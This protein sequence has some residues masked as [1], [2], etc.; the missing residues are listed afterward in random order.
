MIAVAFGVAT[1]FVGRSKGG[2]WLLWFAIG[3][4]LP[5]FGL[6]AAFLTRDEQRE[7]ERPCPSCGSVVKLYVQICP[8]CGAELY[9]PDPSEVSMPPPRK[10]R[11]SPD[12]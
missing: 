3:T 11:F 9:L 4:V 5:G 10:S 2:S 7:P 1:G 6:A 12:E 8:R